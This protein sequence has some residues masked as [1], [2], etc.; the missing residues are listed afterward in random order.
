[1]AYYCHGDYVPWCWREVWAFSTR[2][3]LAC[4]EYRIAPAY[5][6]LH[7]L[8]EPNLYF[9]ARASLKHTDAKKMYHQSINKSKSPLH[10]I[11]QL[12]HHRRTILGWLLLQL[13]Q[14]ITTTKMRSVALLFVAALA[15][16]SAQDAY[17]HQ[18]R[19]DRMLS[20][21]TAKASKASSAKSSKTWVALFHTAWV[22][23]F[24][25]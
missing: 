24:A 10:L 14:S 9:L 22:R 17:N 21:A 7:F 12:Y 1:M 18:L 3:H 5:L 23:S 16:A 11:N 6:K 13:N 19:G 25:T 4:A 20:V 2:V 8:A 15:S